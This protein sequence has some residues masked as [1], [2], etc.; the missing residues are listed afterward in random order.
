M[1]KI[2]TDTQGMAC[3]APTETRGAVQWVKQLF[4]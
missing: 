4:V 2:N 3:H 1:G